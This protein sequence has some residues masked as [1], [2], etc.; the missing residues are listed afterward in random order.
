MSLSRELKELEEELS[1]KS[2]S[3][4]IQAIHKVIGHMNMGKNVS[5]LFFSV[6]KCLEIQNA[7]IKKLVYLYIT[8]YSQD[9]PQE[10]IMSVNSFIRDAKDKSNSIV[11]AMAIRT[12]GCLRVRDLNEYLV[13]PLL[14][15]LSDDDSY[16]KKTAVLAVLKINEISP[17]IVQNAKIIPKLQAILEQDKNPYVISNTLLALYEIEQQKFVYKQTK[18]HNFDADDDRKGAHGASGMQRFVY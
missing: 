2:T 3:K 14:E 13:Q 7:E 5:S 9:F 18:V 15:A 6:M 17:D 4:K 11:R 16:V 10:T 1:S 12:M 8:Q